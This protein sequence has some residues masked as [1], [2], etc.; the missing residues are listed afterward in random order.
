[1]EDKAERGQKT[2][3]NEQTILSWLDSK[4]LDS[5]LYVSFGSLARLAPEQILEIA[6]GLEAS[7]HP[8]IWV[9][10]KILKSTGQNG[11][12]K[13]NLLPSGLEDRIKESRRG[14]II[15]GWAP[16]LFFF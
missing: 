6:H 10:G 12:S 8:F 2:S 9:I 14:L 16:Q 4:E 3:V 15:R 7:N 1:V 11:E 5:V 13:E